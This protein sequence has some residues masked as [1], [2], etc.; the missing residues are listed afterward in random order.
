VLFVVHT[1]SEK[2]KSYITM[3]IFG[4]NKKVKD[5]NINNVES[6]E[7]NEENENS[8]V[9]KD[10]HEQFTRVVVLDDIKNYNA[11]HARDGVHLFPF[12]LCL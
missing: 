4:R 9:L 8:Q 1:K 10:Q 11:S 2:S 12:A 7:D 5:I 3:M 6:V